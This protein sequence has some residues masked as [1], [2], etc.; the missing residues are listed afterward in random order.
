M[1]T[2]TH[3]LKVEPDE[4]TNVSNG[5]INCTLMVTSGQELRIHVGG[6]RPF[7]ETPDHIKVTGPGGSS[8]RASVVTVLDLEG[9]A[10][11]WVQAEV[12]DTEVTVVRGPATI[13]L[14]L[15]D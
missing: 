6:E 15:A 2:T 3:R 11:L 12:E 7:A 14:T 8:S 4:Y 9:E 1:S 10:E 13:M 5:N